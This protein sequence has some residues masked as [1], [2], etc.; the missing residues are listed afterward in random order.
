MSEFSCW[1][2][3]VEWLDDSLYVFH[4]TVPD[5]KYGADGPTQAIDYVLEKY[6]APR[7][8]RRFMDKG[9]AEKVYAAHSEHVSG[10]SLK[11]I[12][13]PEYELDQTL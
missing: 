13:Q 11:G 1:H 7:D 9:R 6:M 4:F 2:V 8:G 10:F 5:G 3:W 12:N